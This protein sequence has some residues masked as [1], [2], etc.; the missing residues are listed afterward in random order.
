[1]FTFITTWKRT[2]DVK[3]GFWLFS[4]LLIVLTALCVGR[5]S[6]VEIFV[7]VTLYAS[8][9]IGWIMQGH[10]IDGVER[11]PDVVAP[12]LLLLGFIVP[13]NI[14]T[15]YA[16]WIIT[17]YLILNIGY[18]VVSVFSILKVYWVWVNSKK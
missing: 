4:A 15:E 1:M 5:F 9:Y 14:I 17:S 6:N 3:Y 18:L 7:I 8:L 10:L 2:P 12:L 11:K 16:F 13:I